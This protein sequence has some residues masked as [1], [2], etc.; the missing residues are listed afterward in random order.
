MNTTHLIRHTERLDTLCYR[1]MRPADQEQRRV[2]I[3]QAFEAMA[4]DLGKIAIGTDR[5]QWGAIHA[6]MMELR[7]ASVNFD[8]SRI[9]DFKHVGAEAALV[10]AL[11][12]FAS[13]LGFI[14]EDAG[15]TPAWIDDDAARA[16]VEGLDGPVV[17][18]AAE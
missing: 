3:V 2:E 9:G 12:A 18:E 17:R 10:T 1:L 11:H 4:T 5:P 7:I 8:E 16:A 14:L 6:A 15:G 13:K